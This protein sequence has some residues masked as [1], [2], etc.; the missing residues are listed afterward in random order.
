MK[1][2]VWVHCGA[3]FP[4]S[5]QVVDPIKFHVARRT[6]RQAR[7]LQSQLEEFLTWNSAEVLHGLLGGAA[8]SIHH[9]EQQTTK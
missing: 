6:I 5:G 8:V 3:D 4:N 1:G 7:L 2:V 9:V